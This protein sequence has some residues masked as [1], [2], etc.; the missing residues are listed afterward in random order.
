MKEQPVPDIEDLE[1]ALEWLEK[2]RWVFVL[3]G[4]KKKFCLVV[5]EKEFRMG[6]SVK[7]QSKGDTPLSCVKDLLAKIYYA[8]LKD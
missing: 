1:G 3:S 7:F 5:A 4:Y 2:N 6:Y 8:D